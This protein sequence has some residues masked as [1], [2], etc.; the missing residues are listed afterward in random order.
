MTLRTAPSLDSAGRPSTT[1]REEAEED[2]YPDAARVVITAVRFWAWTIFVIVATLLAAAIATGGISRPLRYE[3]PDGYRG[4][5]LIQWFD[6][7]CASLRGDGLGEVLVVPDGGR[8]CTSSAPRQGLHSVEYSVRTPTGGA[9]IGPFADH[10]Q[11]ADGRVLSRTVLRPRP[12]AGVDTAA[13]GRLEL[14]P[15]ISLSERNST[16]TNRFSHSSIER[17]ARS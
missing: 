16:A 17:T 11:V 6:A 4:W 1:G 10:D 5:V 8:A 12:R 3:L 9:V 13:A 7:R 15:R 14:L 2:G